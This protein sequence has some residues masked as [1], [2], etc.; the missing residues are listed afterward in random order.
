MQFAKL[1]VEGDHL[2]RMWSRIIALLT[3]NAFCNILLVSWSKL[4]RLRIYLTLMPSLL[5]DF[6]GLWSEIQQVGQ[7]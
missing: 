3:I 6:D 2:L 4:P 7:S 5:D 1:L